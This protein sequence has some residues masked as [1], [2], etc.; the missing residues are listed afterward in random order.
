MEKN[1][2]STYE[3]K[4]AFFSLKTNKSPRYDEINFKVVKKSFEE[5]NE[6]LKHLIYH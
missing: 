4:E 6:P 2:L 5:I 1:S 3:L